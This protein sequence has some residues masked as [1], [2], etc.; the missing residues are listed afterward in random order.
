MLP[1]GLPAGLLGG[2]PVGVPLV[3]CIAAEIEA[4]VRPAANSKMQRMA[5]EGRWWWL[6]WLW[7]LWCWGG[8]EGSPGEGGG[9]VGAAFGDAAR[10]RVAQARGEQ[11]AD[12]AK[13]GAVC[14][15]CGRQRGRV[16]CVSQLVSA[17]SLILF[18]DPVL[19]AP[20]V[21]SR[22]ALEILI[23]NWV[24]LSRGGRRHH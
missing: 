5:A 16:G 19:R 6:W 12:M 22:S 8:G 4:T 14:G 2:V 20:A 23:N 10:M 21:A 7:W 24:S 17:P 15:R 9:A 1:A 3:A 11:N 13:R 18:T